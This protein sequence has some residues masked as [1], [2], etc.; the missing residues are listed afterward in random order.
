[1]IFAAGWT[2][3]VGSFYV[4]VHFFFV[5]DIEGHH[6]LGATVGVNFSG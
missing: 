4:P 2:P 6:K 1:M 5:P 3:R